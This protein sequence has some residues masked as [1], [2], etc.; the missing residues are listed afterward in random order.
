MTI[1]KTFTAY[2][3]A[4]VFGVSTVLLTVIL[5]SGQALPSLGFIVQELALALAFRGAYKSL[6]G[7]DYVTP[8]LEFIGMVTATEPR[9]TPGT[10]IEATA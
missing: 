6:D 8:V 2:V 7:R 9:T 1:D 5:G 4:L 10:V 3:M